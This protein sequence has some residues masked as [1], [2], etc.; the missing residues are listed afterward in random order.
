ML[1]DMMIQMNDRQL[2]TLVQLQAFLDGTTTVDF[3]V[4]AE[5]RYGFIGRTVRRFSYRGAEACAESGDAA[6]SR[7]GERLLASAAH[8][9]S[10]AR[11]G[12][13]PAHRL[14]HRPPD[15]IVLLH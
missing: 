8:A 11:H 9:A 7:A 5:E 14:R 13:C 3:A 12:A 4:I 10:Q 15:R 1:R 6:V 2:Q